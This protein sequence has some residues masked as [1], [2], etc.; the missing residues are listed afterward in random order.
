MTLAAPPHGLPPAH[1]GCTCSCHRVPGI[2]HF[3]PCCRPKLNMPTDPE[4]YRQKAG[5]EGDSAIS[6]GVPDK[7]VANMAERLRPRH[8]ADEP[9][10]RAVVS[11]DH[12]ERRRAVSAYLVE[13]NALKSEASAELSR[14]SAENAELRK[15][16]DEA[17]EMLKPFA[18]YMGET[19]DL[20]HKGQPLPDS[21]GVGWVYL[22]QGDFR[23]ARTFINSIKEPK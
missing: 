2:M 4:W 13:N 20:N 12:M 17:V 1:G 23:R 19:G 9:L 10:A 21:E 7:P 3:A 18:E 11:D 14:L 16:R 8:I 6:A 22:T 15:E 5:L